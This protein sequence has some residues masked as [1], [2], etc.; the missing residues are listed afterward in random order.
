VEIL[1]SLILS[2]LQLAAVN[3]RQ[4]RIIKLLR[5]ARLVRG[6]KV[7]RFLR[8]VSGLRTLTLSIFNTLKA[9]VW[10]MVLVFGLVFSVGVSL[11]QLVSDHCRYE[12]VVKSGDK[13][14]VPYCDSEPLRIYWANTS[15]SMLTLFKAITGGIS[16]DDATRALRE[17]SAVAT[18]MFLIFQFFSVFAMLNVVTGVF[19]HSAIESSNSDK[20]IASLKQ[21]SNERNYV[22]TIRK[23]FSE[24]DDDNSDCV[25][26]DEFERALED[27][28]M[29]AYLE[30][31][32]IDTRDAWSLFK[33]LDADRSGMIDLEEFVSGCLQLRGPAK[34]IHV[35]RLSFDFRSTKAALS[36]FEMDLSNHLE[37]MRRSLRTILRLHDQ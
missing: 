26:I 34:A 28:R 10:T 37:N 30:S 18:F 31:V 20:E 29:S 13:N 3:V 6:I 22:E 21:L 9:L 36:N 24:L 2:G 1:F 35:A 32:D 5:I 4:F 17:V 33:M 14:A 23:F 16:W 15:E 25:T 7:L 27:E 8:F 19:C 12:A 11:T